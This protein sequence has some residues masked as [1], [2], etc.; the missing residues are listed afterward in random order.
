MAQNARRSRNRSAAVAVLASGGLDSA[1]LVAQA[2]NR[3]RAVVPVYVRCGLVWE[4]AEIHWL[5]RY[6]KALRHPAIQ[7]LAVVRAPVKAL[8]GAHWS[9]TGRGVP[10]YRSRDAGMYLPGRNVLLLSA[11]GVLA[12]RRRVPTVMIGTL[13]GNPFPDSRRAFFRSMSRTL[14]L[15]LHYNISIQAPFSGLTKAQVLRRGRGLPLHLT[16]SCARPRGIRPCGGCNKCA[17]R[18]R[19]L[20]AVRA[21]S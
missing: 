6:L 1:V 10:G 9:L 13:R 21:S 15:G 5:R 4:A 16:L 8:Y 14:S 3:A 7:P 20:R 19:A 12:A 2:L 18:D 11:A 17:E